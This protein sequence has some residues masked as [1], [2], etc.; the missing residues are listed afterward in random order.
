MSQLSKKILDDILE[1]RLVTA[2]EDITAAVEFL[3]YE[4]IL[5]EEFRMLGE[6]YDEADEEEMEDDEESDEE[7]EEEDSECDCEDPEDCECED[8]EESD[9]E[10]DEEMEDEV[11]YDD[12]D[13]EMITEGKRIVKRVNAKGKVIRKVKCSAGMKA[14]DGKCV[15]MGGKEKLTRRK[16]LI[17]RARTMKRKS[18]GAKRRAMMKRQRALRKRSGMGL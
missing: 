4:N 9:E 11:E 3:S 6:S 15:R 12:E 14:K 18:A 2:K 8:S 1:G 13:G 5:R 7:S 16:A 10:S 17:K